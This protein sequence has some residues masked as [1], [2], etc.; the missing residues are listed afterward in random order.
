[1]D[2]F[3]NYGRGDV[4]NRLIDDFNIDE[5]ESNCILYQD[6]KIDIKLYTSIF[7]HINFFDVIF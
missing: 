7:T 1:M 6:I 4:F 5:D 3:N 2:I